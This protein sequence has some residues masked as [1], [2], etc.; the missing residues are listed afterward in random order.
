MPRS[1]CASMSSGRWPGTAFNSY[2]A[3]CGSGRAREAGNSVDAPASPVF[4]GMPAPTG[5]APDLGQVYCWWERARPR[6]RQ[7]G[8]WHRL[9]RCSRACPLLQGL[10]RAWG[11]FTAGGSAPAKQATRW[12][13]PAAPVFAGMPAPTGTAP[14]L[15]Q[16]YCWWERARPRSRQRGGWHR[17]R[18][19][20]RACPLLQGPRRAWGRFTAGRCS[21]T[22]AFPNGNESPASAPGTH[23][24]GSA[25][26]PA[27][28][29]P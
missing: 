10:R 20:S 11:R 5:T 4:A 25:A 3:H 18:R 1:W 8:G 26:S 7:R 17:L 16:V 22:W 23:Q 12:V 19:C 24:R 21:G 13:A 28:P 2:T 14:G 29:A 9:R 27:P 6:S 15:G